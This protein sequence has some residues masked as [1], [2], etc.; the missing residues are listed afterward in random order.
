MKNLVW[1][2]DW[3]DSNGKVIYDHGFCNDVDEATTQINRKL[4]RYG[5]SQ[6]ETRVT[7][8]PNPFK[9]IKEDED[10]HC[11]S[12][13]CFKMQQSSFK[14]SLDWCGDRIR[15]LQTKVN[16]LESKIRYT[17]DYYHQ[18]EKRLEEIEENL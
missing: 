14:N 13:D 8:K 10:P 18:H 6:S 2:I 4:K 17:N 16:D 1:Q 15:E 12:F 5:L 7:I 9:E 3:K 11:I